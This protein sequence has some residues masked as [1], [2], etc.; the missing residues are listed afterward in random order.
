M[1]D[2]KGDGGSFCLEE[3][4][5]AV[6]QVCMWSEG[7]VSRVEL[8]CS[9]SWLHVEKR[10]KEGCQQALDSCT[11][12]LWASQRDGRVSLQISVDLLVLCENNFF[13]AVM[14]EV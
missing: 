7:Y 3:G 11:L 6:G 1:W 9:L 10:V 13:A 5:L 14:P 12:H 2:H 4:L 8:P